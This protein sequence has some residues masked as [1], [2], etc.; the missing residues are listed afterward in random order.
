[1][2][3]RWLAKNLWN[4]KVLKIVTILNLCTI[5]NASLFHQMLNVG[6]Q[7]EFQDV[8]HHYSLC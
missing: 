6:K 2:F 5:E 7:T 3:L 4:W 8:L 1:M